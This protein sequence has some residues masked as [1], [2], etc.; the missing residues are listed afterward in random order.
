MTDLPARASESPP[1]LTVTAPAHSRKSAG[2]AVTSRGEDEEHAE[3]G[4]AEVVLDDIDAR[5]G[6]AT[7]L[8]RTFIGLYLRPLGGEI[9][10]SALVQLAGDLGIPAPQARTAITRLKQRGLLLSSDSGG[11][12]LNP[13]ATGMLERGDDRIFTVR[14]MQ[15][16][17][18]WMLV[19]ATVPETR[20]DL[21]HQ[22]RRRL[23]F[24]GAGAVSAG[25]WILPGHLDAEVEALLE[26]IGAREFATL[27][28]TADPRPA[29]PLADAARSWWDLEALRAEHERF[30]ASVD[31]LDTA[32]PFAAHVHL[33]D[34]WRVLPYTDP[35]LP[36]SLLPTDWPGARSA[37]VFTALSDRLTTPAWQHVLAVVSST[38][39]AASPR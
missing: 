5:P 3:T 1:L 28:R 6:S 13:A 19:S 21:R 23:Q 26:E 18:E 39:A 38:T 30:L 7:S 8:L 11:H 33:I 14:T 32:A 34:S 2:A 27:F 16:G 35:G 25:L 37:E 22:L 20:R 17:D 24:I 36:A 31:A 9:A 12:A 15:P 29:Q 10:P 4:H